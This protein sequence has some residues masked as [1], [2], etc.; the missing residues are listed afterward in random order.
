M[1]ELRRIFL[2][3]HTWLGLHVAILLG[4]VLITGSVL[5]MADEIEM[6]FHPRAWVSA[7]ADEAAH[8]SFAEIYDALKTAY[9]ETAIMWVEKRP[10]A[11]LADRTFTRT[12]WGEEITIWT[13]PETAE[14]LDVTRTIGFRRI[15]HGLH[16]DLLI[17]LA[18][19][20]LF[21]TALSIVVLTS[22]IT[23]LVVYRRFWRGFFRL[24]A[25]GADGRTWLGGLHR[26]IGLWT[27][28]FLLIVGLSSAVFFARTLG[29]ADMGPKPA[30]ATERAGLLPDSADTAMIA[31]AEQAAMAALPDVAFEKMT[32]PYNARGGI[33]FEGR[34]RDALLVRDGETVSIDPSDFAVLGITHIE[35]RGGAARLEPL[36]KVFHY[37]TVGGTT[38]R[39]IWVVFGLASGGL[40]LTGAL[41]YAARQRADTGAGRTI[42]RG[43][44]LFRWAYLLLIL[45]MIAVVVLQYGP[46]GVKWAG[47]PPPVEAKDYVRLASKGKLRLGKELPLRL[48][49][50]A[51][52]VVSATITQGPGTPRP[53]ELKPAGKNRAATFGLRGTP[54]DNSVEIELTLQSGEVKSFTYRLGNAIW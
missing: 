33:V 21:I 5:V 15:L 8:A 10:T 42:W 30:I 27:M 18:P 53:L 44:G 25:R 31:A 20:R 54:R 34:P 36:T 29:L 38:T 50:S 52:E 23:G 14:V 11:F 51:P 40:V 41:I 9:P 7:P 13:H 32:M 19:A 6:V 2:K 4:F 26:L 12:A 16:E 49:V 35:D 28:P 43:L 17:P 39:L 46:P 24:P 48:T 47:I 3:I 22:V 37:G 1:R 45:G